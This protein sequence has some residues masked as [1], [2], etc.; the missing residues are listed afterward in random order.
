MRRLAIILLLAPLLALAQTSYVD[1][2]K[3]LTAEQLHATGLDTLSP[4]QLA[5]L[6]RLL[7]DDGAAA[8]AATAATAAP[9]ATT[10][11]A[12][13][14]PPAPMHIG[15]EEGP[16]HS[17]LVGTLSGWGP[18]TEFVLANGQK[19]KVLKGSYQLRAP[20]QAPEVDIVP[21]IA[22]RWFFKLDEDTPGPRVYR[23]E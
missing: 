7:R 1:L 22:G 15:L 10:A 12:S 9:A 2:E 8:T 14:P 13:A 11:P 3:R 19:W 4:A 20:V 5:L 23:V 18:G 17:R 21:G 6:N 16:V